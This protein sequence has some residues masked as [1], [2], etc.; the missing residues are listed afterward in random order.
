MA[1]SGLQRRRAAAS[2]ATE[3]EDFDGSWS[4]SGNGS[5]GSTSHAADNGAAN[6]GPSASHAGT[7]FEGG[8]KIAFDPR[9]LEQDSA[10]TRA[11]GGRMPR[12][13]LM[14]EVLLLGL[15]DK[16][17]HESLVH[18]LCANLLPLSGLPFILE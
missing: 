10:D 4:A 6:G 2:S 17:V 18:S 13:T 9:D 11:S 16:Q 3:D 1:T 8:S 15:K 12:L 5:A 7:A 14:E